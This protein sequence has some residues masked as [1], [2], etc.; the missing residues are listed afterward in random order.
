[1]NQAK[2]NTIKDGNKVTS[3]DQI[4]TATTTWDKNGNTS[5]G[6]PSDIGPQ[7]PKVSATPA[8]G[9]KPAGTYQITLKV[10]GDNVSASKYTTN[11][12]DPM[13]SGTS[14]SDG[15]IINVSLAKD[16]SVVLKLYAKNDA[17]ESTEQY[18]FKEG[19]AVKSVF[20]WDNV[21]CYFVLTDRFVN[22]NK[23]NDHSY[24]RECDRNGNPIPNSNYENRPGTFN[25]GD[26]V[27]L[28]SK[29]NDGYFTD[30]GVNAIW[31]TSPLEQIHG[32]VA[33]GGPDGSFKHYGYHG[34]YVLD[35]T[36]IDANMGTEQE[37]EA[38]IAAC[39]AK[40]IR[41]VIDV[42]INHFGYEN[43]K[44][45]SEFNYG[46][47][48][49]GWEDYYFNATDGSANYDT[50]LA[51]KMDFGSSNWSQ[52]YGGAWVRKDDIAG[53]YDRRVFWAI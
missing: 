26:L 37:F 52:W 13:T 8:G 6:V 36:E 38:F 39:H 10:T 15:T 4:L 23:A 45:M 3:D 51:P 49:S 35:P 50:G 27:G 12:M 22:G 21:N 9:V 53:G 2:V 28:T 34:Y 31:I 29:V 20:S 43:L 19:E 47:L 7:P 44:D 24:G 48:R 40:G 41:V 14:F 30:L 33:G 25:G 46:G 32:W 16:S 1:M 42:V 17:G 18:T 11:G 5:S